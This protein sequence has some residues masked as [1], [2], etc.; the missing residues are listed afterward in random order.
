M[1]GKEEEV[2]ERKGETNNGEEGKIE[3]ENVKK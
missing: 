2:K 3:N 1:E